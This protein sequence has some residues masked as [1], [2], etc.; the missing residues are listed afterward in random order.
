MK[1][2]A[3]AAALLAT[4]CIHRNLISVRDVPGTTTTL[5]ETSDSLNLYVYAQVKHVFWQCKEQALT[6][7]C[8]RA[9]EGTTDLSCPTGNSLTVTSNVR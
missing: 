2:L 5:I 4:G 8:E 3:L 9:C 1:T 7:S 6:L